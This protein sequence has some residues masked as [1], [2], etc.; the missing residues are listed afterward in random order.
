MEDQVQ[1]TNNSQKPEEPLE[2]PIVSTEEVDTLLGGPD[3]D[4][5]IFRN[6]FD[7][8][9]PLSP[10]TSEIGTSEGE[11]IL[12]TEGNDVILGRDGND[13]IS[14]FKGDDFLDGQGGDDLLFSGQDNDIV[15]G[16][17]GS[18]T[19]FGDRGAD[20]VYGGDGKDLLFGNQDNDTIF[21]DSGDDEIYGGQGNDSLIGG[22]GSDL[23]L[24]DRG[25]DTLFGASRA[26]EGYARVADFDSNEDTILLSGSADRYELISTQDLSVQTGVFL[27][28]GTA[29]LQMSLG[30]DREL[31]AVIEGTSSLDLNDSYFQFL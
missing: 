5:F 4:V 18:D 14:S 11:E 22:S 16:S 10:P 17:D 12:G 19:L 9:S 3:A 28:S 6:H 31:I 2:P 21:G 27:P 20:V 15:V 7:Q 25:E 1:D 29:I 23:L 24:G 30:G 13:T 8:L 26:G